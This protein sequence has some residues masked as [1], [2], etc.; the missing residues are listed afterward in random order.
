MSIEISL[1]N[2]KQQE[3][4]EAMK[5]TASSLS[6]L[7]KE[8]KNNYNWY[9][10]EKHYLSFWD[11]NLAQIGKQNKDYFSPNLKLEKKNIAPGVHI[12]R[13]AWLN[14]YVVQPGDTLSTIREKL[15][16]TSEFSYLTDPQYDPTT[17]G[18]KTRS[19]NIPAEKLQV[20]MYIPIPL[21]NKV[22]EISPQNFVNYGY[23]AIHEMEN[24]YGT[25]KSDI[26]ELLS[27]VSE[28][29]ILISMLAFAR[30]ET[31]GDYSKFTEDLGTAELHRREPL[32]SAFSFTYFHIL[33][34]KNADGSPWPWLQARQNLWLTEWQCYHPKNAA[35][36]FLAYRIEKK[37][38]LNVWVKNKNKE[39][40]E[41][42]EPLAPLYT[43]TDL[44]PLTE[45]NI[46]RS[47]T[48]YNGSSTYIEKLSPN[49]TYATKLLNGE[50]VY[51]DNIN[52]EKYWFVYNGLNS[53]FKHT[54]RYTT[55]D[56]VN[57]IDSL[58]QTT[59][60]KFNLLK[61]KD[62]PKITE[63]NIINGSGKPITWKIIPDKVF[64]ALD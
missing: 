45:K 7:Q 9:P 24:E 46:A 34:E 3:N 48:L 16:H 27:L 28:K 51:Y 22:R 23:E 44:I 56:G 18:N 10:F 52:L 31:A 35:K 36:L 19:F 54:Y 57:T 53:K 43:L 38:Q 25:Y 60:K 11:N 8:V 17:K 26:Q 42:W 64:I 49:F 4:N 59:V 21:D 33:M 63:K 29:D 32:Y 2:N 15:M 40:N 61:A 58:L 30:S 12:I 47:G 1:H 14:F 39:R 41:K 37:N 55:P 5:E 13:D 62:C 50:I 6:F 20:W